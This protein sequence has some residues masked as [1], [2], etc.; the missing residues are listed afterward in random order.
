MNN[1]QMDTR[2][3]TMNMQW[4]ISRQGGIKKSGDSRC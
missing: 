1:I 3:Y 4:K 2:F